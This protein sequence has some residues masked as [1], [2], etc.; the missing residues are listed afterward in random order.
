M[1][2]EPPIL[3]T[4]NSLSSDHPCILNQSITHLIHNNDI[5]DWQSLSACDHLAVYYKTPQHNSICDLDMD[6]GIP[7]KQFIISLAQVFL[8]VKCDF[9]TRMCDIACVFVISRKELFKV[10]SIVSVDLLLDN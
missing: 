1:P 5:A 6:I 2:R 3:T 9:A 10:V 4:I 7:H 8:T